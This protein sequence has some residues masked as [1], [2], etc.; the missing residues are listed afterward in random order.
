MG[1]EMTIASVH[2][3]MKKSN[4]TC[5]ELINMYLERIQKYDKKGPHI[6]SVIC[7]NPKSLDMAHQL[8]LAFAQNGITKPLHGIPVLL[9]DNIDTKDMPT[10]AGSI[11]LK[12]V[13]PSDDAHIVRK[14]KEAGAI[15]LAKVNLHEFAVWGETVSSI[16]G[17]TFNPYDLTR[18]PGGSSGG[19][20]AAIAADFGLIGIGTD[21]INSI[22]SPASACSLV[23]LRPTTGLV[24]RNGIVPYSQ[25]QDTAGPIMRTVE[26][27]AKVLDIIA[28]KEDRTPSY[29]A[30][31]KREGLNKKRIGILHSFFGQDQIHNQVNGILLNGLQIMK[32]NGA[33]L[34]DIEE[35]I[36]S[37]A[38]VSNVSV[39]LYELRPHLNQYLKSL[40]KKSTYHSLEEIIASGKYHEGI[41]DPIMHAQTLDMNTKE[42][43]QRQIKRKETQ[44]LIMTI[45][46]KYNLDALVYP[47]QKRPVVKVGQVQVDRN[48]VLASVTGYPSIVI[49]AGFTQPT[50]TA[51][52]GLP[53][54]MEFLGKQWQEPTL[55]EMAYG[56]EQ[57]TKYRMPPML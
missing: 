10:T 5:V 4:L 7:I 32:E 51:P 36:S 3:A 52:L 1:A 24:P 35:D 43:E 25:T 16:L 53:V 49:P 11:A 41:R 38:L 44:H 56:F 17:Q 12:G 57:L 28:E 30:Y 42:Y 13:I 40:G 46:E 50:D 55:L 22:R 37:D 9:K 29:T 39:H 2:T 21:T 18:T 54:G 31:L 45:M 6:N 15:I 33:I 34:I 48:G 8:D 14:L 27:T 20:A 26:D 23:G 47:H 19:T